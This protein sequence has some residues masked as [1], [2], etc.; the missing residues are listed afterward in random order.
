MCR[1]TLR[2]AATP[3]PPHR[4]IVV[5]ADGRGADA[6]TVAAAA[7]AARRTLGDDEKTGD[8]TDGGA[9]E[10]NEEDGGGV[11]SVRA[12]DLS[13]ALA[14]A[15]FDRPALKASAVFTCLSNG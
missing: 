14:F 3:L 1:A 13:L 5:G 8:D 6:A 9:G 7:D 4:A 12:E 10:G 15:E 11:A 2:A